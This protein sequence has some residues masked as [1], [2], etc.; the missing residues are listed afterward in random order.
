MKDILHLLQDIEADMPEDSPYM[1]Q[2]N[3]TQIS[4]VLKAIKRN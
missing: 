1:L 2:V 3:L 4:Q